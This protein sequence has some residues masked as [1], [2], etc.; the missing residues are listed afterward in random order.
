MKGGAEFK[1]EILRKCLDALEAVGFTRYRKDHVDWPMEHGFHCWVGLNTALEDGCLD[2][3]PFV[4]VHVVPIMKFYTSQE[5]SK[6]RRTTA[7]YAVHMGELAP[8]VPVFRFNRDTDVEAEAQR[9]ARLYLDIGL[10]YALSIGDYGQLLPLLRARLPMLGGY[11]E[12]VA[13]CLYLMGQKDEAKVLVEGFLQS[14]PGYFDE[15]AL[16]FLSKF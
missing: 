13:S 7:T 15:F 5:G 11:P 1:K 16:R 14:H 6:Y 4:G 12:L 8:K 2:V 3:N 10:T 9:L